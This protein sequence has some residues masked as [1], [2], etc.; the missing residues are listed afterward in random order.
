MAPRK[1]TG[2]LRCPPMRTLRSVLFN[3]ELA[4]YLVNLG[5]SGDGTVD[6]VLTQ[7]YDNFEGT[8]IDYNGNEIDIETSFIDADF[9]QDTRRR[10]NAYKE[11]A[12]R[13]FQRRL[14]V[15]LVDRIMWLHFARLI[16]TE[17]DKEQ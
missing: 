13:R 15:D 9:A 2:T 16:Q 11:R 3:E 4:K 7:I 10:V 14:Q 1:V 5:L 12:S 17:L 6:W 8:L